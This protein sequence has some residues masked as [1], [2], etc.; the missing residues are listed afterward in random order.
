M[1]ENLDQGS[2]TD[3]NDKRNQQLIFDNWDVNK[4]FETDAKVV[5]SNLV[6]SRLFFY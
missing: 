5:G 3:P 4:S 6:T 1:V 2:K